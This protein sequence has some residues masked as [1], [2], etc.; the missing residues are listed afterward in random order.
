MLIWTDNAITHIKEFIKET[1]IN[2][3]ET[4]KYY[5]KNNVVILAVLHTRLDI[6]KALKKIKMDIND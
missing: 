3:E 1:R 4:A 5:M 6:Q 2:T